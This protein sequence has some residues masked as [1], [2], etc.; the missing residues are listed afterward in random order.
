MGQTVG[1]EMHNMQGRLN[2]NVRGGLRAQIS[3]PHRGLVVTTRWRTNICLKQSHVL[4]DHE[5]FKHYK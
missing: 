4:T 5:S 2:C 3:S 1:Q